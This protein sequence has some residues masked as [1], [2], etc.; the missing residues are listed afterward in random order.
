MKNERMKPRRL[1]PL[2]LLIV[3]CIPLL[4]WVTVHVL[5]TFDDWNTLS[6]PNFDDDWPKYFLSYGS[7]WR[8]IDALLGYVTRAN[9]RLFPLLN[10]VLILLGHLASVWMV[11]LLC[12]RLRFSTHASAVATAFFFFSPCMVATVLSCD[13]VN[14]TYSHLWGMVAVWCYLCLHGRRRFVLW[15][16][17]VWMAALSKDNGIAW[18]VVPPM[19]AYAFGEADRRTLLRHL[20]FGV[21]VAVA[22][23][24]VR[25][26]LPHTGI[27]NPDYS[28]FI[29]IKKLRELVMLAG[30]T[31]VAADYVSL[32]HAPSR[33]LPL[34]AAT[35]ALSLPLLWVLF[36]RPGRTL[37]RSRRLWGL[38]AAM[39]T[40]LS[41]HL[42]ITLSVM[43]AYAGLGM[44]ALIVGL[45][46]DVRD[47]EQG[48]RSTGQGSRW[49][50]DVYLALWL[51]AALVT[52]AHHAYLSWKTSLASRDLAE[53]TLAQMPAPVERVYCVTVE[54][55]VRG[56]S[57][58][59]VRAEDAFGWGGAVSHATGYKWPRVLRGTV[60]SHADSAQ[61]ATVVAQAFDEGFQSVW[62]VQDGH[63]RVI[64]CPLR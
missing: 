50:P 54:P 62:V 52:D 13:S 5:P 3:L 36:V 37:W 32:V 14:Q 42:L 56:F 10:H 23:G 15:A 6:S 8:P 57:S 16:V 48:I 19:L 44:A 43:N 24:A 12:R 53:E 40:A 51:C 34:F 63:V 22:Y 58:F 41:P 25:M 2:L 1:H 28:T 64:P 20:S 26:S 30:Y 39:L 38:V 11:W 17:L 55:A 21:A 9:Y 31:W 18:A 45:A 35:C 4:C 7:V 27:N 47:K 46:V 49:K 29:P 59:C 60:L 33:N 61:V